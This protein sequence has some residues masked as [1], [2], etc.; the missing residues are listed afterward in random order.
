MSQNNPATTYAGLD[1]HKATL[2]LQLQTTGQELPNTP[3]GRRRL[4]EILRAAPGPVQLLC[5]ASGGYERAV[6]MA[7][8]KANLAYTLLNARRVLDFAKARGTRAKTDRIDAAILAAYG[9]A[10]RPAL[11]FYD[12][13][14]ILCS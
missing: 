9:A 4:M 8:R 3:A 13:W 11:A 10:L 2:Q 14:R 5:E 12:R 6:L 7:L 1:I